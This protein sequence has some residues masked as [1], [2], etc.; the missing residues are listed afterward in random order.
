MERRTR[1]A[2]SMLVANRGLFVTQK[3]VDSHIGCALSQIKKAKGTNKRVWNPWPEEPPQA[4][5]YCL[6][7]GDAKGRAIPVREAD[8]SLSNCK[9]TRLV[10]NRAADMFA[11]YDY[12]APTGGIFHGGM[13][14]ETA[15]AEISGAKVGGNEVGSMDLKFAPGNIKSGDYRF[16]VGT[17]G[18]VTL[19]ASPATPMRVAWLVF[20][21]VEPHG[22]PLFFADPLDITI[23]G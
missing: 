14:V 11:L 1:T 17:A 9:V 12:G 5:D 8:V 2:H 15:V 20:P 4:E 16:D 21:L 7:L 3:A 13:L 18:S 10:G 19:V 23:W 22:L 6:F